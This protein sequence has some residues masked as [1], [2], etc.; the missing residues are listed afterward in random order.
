[1]DAASDGTSRGVRRVAGYLEDS[2]GP[3]EYMVA[4]AAVVDT[5]ET[6]ATVLAWLALEDTGRSDHV[7]QA[8]DCIAAVSRPGLSRLR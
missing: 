7:T 4:P 6:L 8:V 5:V 1:M 3:P 2:R